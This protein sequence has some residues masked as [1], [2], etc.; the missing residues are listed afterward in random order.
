MGG[1]VSSYLSVADVAKHIGVSKMTVYRLAESGDIPSLR[2]GRSIR[3]DAEGLKEYIA[4]N[5][6]TSEEAE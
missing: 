1:I 6:T 5:T 2:F 4:T 3:I